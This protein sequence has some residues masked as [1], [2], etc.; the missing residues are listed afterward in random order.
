MGMS[1]AV[2][3]EETYDFSILYSIAGIALKFFTAEI[4][5]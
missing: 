5:L 2:L 3:A 1:T 4:P